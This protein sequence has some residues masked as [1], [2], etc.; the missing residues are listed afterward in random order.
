[1]Y[2]RNYKTFRWAEIL[3]TCVT[4]KLYIHN[5]NI[6]IHI[7]DLQRNTITD[8]NSNS[9]ILQHAGYPG[10][11]FTRVPR[12]HSFIYK[13]PHTYPITQPQTETNAHVTSI[14]PTLANKR[15]N[16]SR[17]NHRHIWYYLG[18]VTGYVQLWTTKTVTSVN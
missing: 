3:D 8:A 15:L 2:F 7:K 9:N 4:G 16:A 1:L 14:L 11:H 10:N 5:I 18:K 13:Q 17:N 6:R 12:K